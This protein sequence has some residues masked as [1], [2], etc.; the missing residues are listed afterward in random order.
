MTRIGKGRGIYD[1]IRKCLQYL[2]A[3]NTAEILVMLVAILAGW[4]IPLLPLQILWINLVTD[5]LPA[6]A[7]AADP[8]D[9]GVLSRPPRRRADSFLDREFC[10]RLLG[11]GLMSAGVTLA[12]FAWGLFVVR[13][14]AVARSLAFSTL[15]CEELLRSL[16]VRSLDHPLWRNPAPPNR[17]LLGVI[18]VS[19]L[20]QIVLHETPALHGPFGTR[21]MDLTTTACVFLLGS[22][23][24]LVLEFAKLR[25]RPSRIA[26]GHSPAC[27]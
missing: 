5:G 27:D 26:A 13:D 25:R 14:V 24:L 3:G 15:V 23:P 2:L 19:L 9:P 20:I 12:A 22:V 17:W 18:P 10:F 16:G 1:N 4:P 11:I 8:V 7:L 21:P 6:L